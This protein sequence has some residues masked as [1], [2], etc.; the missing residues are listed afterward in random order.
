MRPLLAMTAIAALISA[1]GL[2]LP[3]A[4][5]TPPTPASRSKGCTLLSSPLVARSA[6]AESFARRFAAL[7]DTSGQWV[8]ADS[9][10]SVPLKDGTVAWL[11][12]D[13]L[14]GQVR[15]G[16]L[17]PTNSSFL[18]NSVVV[19]DGR[20]LT[21]R[22]HGTPQD[23]QSLVPPTGAS[24]WYW[25]GAGTRKPNGDVQV[26]ALKFEKFGVGIF[27]FGW[28][29]NHVA[30][31]DPKTWQL[32]SL[33]PLPS[34]HDIQWGSWIRDDKG[35]MLVYGVEDRG[36]EKF[37]HIARVVGNDLGRTQNWSYWNGSGWSRE[38]DAS[39]RVMPGV[40][41]E[42]SVT[43]YEDGYLL[44]TQDTAEAFSNRVLAYSSCSPTGPFSGPVELF[45]TP[46]TGA[47]GSYGDPNIFTYNA[48]EH[49]EFRRGNNLLV[50]YN[51]NS[52]DSNSLYDD[53]TIYRPR[54]VTVTLTHTGTN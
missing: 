8:G 6:P 45:R 17:S 5:A 21:T 49:P 44:I 7:G 36:A 26:V 41:N 37:M 30:T 3:S 48:H 1:N 13:T 42:Y 47:W 43:P 27:D 25:F 22:V 23:P 14:Y 4:A 11:F 9:T 54:F 28:S 52:F 31:F 38:E 10:Y 20:T 40:G 46:E 29:S 50:T 16:K 35:S 15:Q 33:Q 39:V 19:D 32:R 53:V 24:S 18:N 2:A 51:V 34:S 12:S